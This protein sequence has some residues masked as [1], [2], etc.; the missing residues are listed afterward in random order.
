MEEETWQSQSKQDWLQEFQDVANEIEEYTVP[1][2]AAPIQYDVDFIFLSS[3]LRIVVKYKEYSDRALK[4]SLAVIHCN[5]A[6]Y[7]SWDF[8]RQILTYRNDRELFEKEWNICNELCL[9]NH[10]NYQIWFHKRYLCTILESPQ[11]E[12]YFIEQIL[13]QDSKNYHAWAHRQ[14]IVRYFGCKTGEVEFSLKWIEKDF[15]NNS[16]WNYRY[17]ILLANEEEAWR[18][19]ALRQREVVFALQMLERSLSNESAWMYLWQVIRNEWHLFPNVVQQI[20]KLLIE[21]EN[22][23][24][25]LITWK[26]I[27]VYRGEITKAIQVCR[28]ID[29]P[30]LYYNG[31]LIQCSSSS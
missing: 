2:K 19:E 29:H 4:V 27:L 13:S 21:E 12:L 25:V 30:I 10:K 23:I 22:N 15:R 14:W 16:A 17:F 7:T 26:D 5:P 8:R 28:Y 24:M 6:D 18:D 11:E 31:L 20:E 1:A 9:D 3:L